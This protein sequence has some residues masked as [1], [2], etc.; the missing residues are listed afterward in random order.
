MLL[1]LTSLCLTVTAMSATLFENAGTAGGRLF[2]C[3]EL[4]A[5]PAAAVYAETKAART[6]EKD[7]ETK[8][9]SMAQQQVSA[10]HAAQQKLL[11]AIDRLKGSGTAVLY[12]L[13]RV[14]NGV[15]VRT[16][17]Q[18]L[19]E[20]RNIQGVRRVLPVP[21]QEPM[22]A[23]SVP[24]LGAPEVWESY[25]LTGKNVKIGIIDTGIDYFH[26][27]FG[28]S[29]SVEDYEANDPD[30]LGDYEFPTEKVVGGWDFAGGP[31]R[32][33][34]PDL[35]VPQPDPDPVDYAGHGSHVA[36][37]AAGFG[38]TADGET[39]SGPWTDTRNLPDMKIAPGVAPEALLYALKVFG[40]IE[41]ATALSLAAL[42]WALDPDGDGNFSD[43]LDVVNLSLGSSYGTIYNALTAGTQ[44]AAQA[45]LIIVASAGNSSDVYFI[46]GT[47]GGAENVLSVAASMDDGQIYTAIDVLAPA[48]AAGS[49]YVTR[50]TA[51]P[52][53]EDAQVTGEL[54]DAEPLMACEALGNPDVL[55]GRIALVDRGSCS[56]YDKVLNAQNAGAT[57]VIVV[58]NDPYEPIQVLIDDDEN[59]IQIPSVMIGRAAGQALRAAMAGEPV[60][61]SMTGGEDIVRTELADVIAPFSSRGPKHIQKR[62]ILKPDIAAP[63]M[64]ITSVKSGSGTEGV[65]WRGT[66]MACPHITGMMALLREA[67][68]GWSVNALKALA[69]NTA[70]HDLFRDE[71][72]VPPRISP[73][74]A[75]AGNADITAAL[76]GGVIAYHAARPG[77]V[78]LVFEN[79]DVTGQMTET[80]T[81]RLKNYGAASAQYS[82]NIDPAADV[83]GISFT[84]ADNTITVP[85]AGTA[86]LEITLTAAASGMSLSRAPAVYAAQLDGRPRYSMSEAAGYV[87]FTPA[88]DG[89]KLRVPYYSLARPAASMQAGS[90]ILN[91]VED[92][93]SI[94][95]PLTGTGVET[96][97][98]YPDDIVSL[99][100]PFELK[101]ESGCES[102]GSNGIAEDTDIRYAGVS[103]VGD[104]LYFG[105]VS[106]GLWGTPEEM[107][108]SVYIDTDLDG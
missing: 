67:H 30:V 64:Q 107:Y 42:E 104:T 84:A 46:T 101:Y 102:C 17:D 59:A 93:G 19:K 21:L 9:L 78:S 29:G 54:A 85:A 53:L 69:M 81:I 48:S 92:A 26:A 55:G 58:N 35:D 20:L 41:S 95:I 13:Q 90:D 51:G 76:A 79:I 11:A 62:P 10:N 80:R 23:S 34:D 71:V 57:G 108:F 27:D 60:T 77:A 15:V 87:T 49:H 103:T 98:G 25:G 6:A 63:G 89:P 1:F 39:F 44:Y 65:T 2:V 83:P 52:P 105:I 45:G 56:C 31:Y 3:L 66:S 40:D 61:V 14:L 16:T 7:S 37:S 33:S 47:P 70:T 86:D 75:G 100:T 74:R 5:P 36:G 82:V 88:D 68:P 12:T 18:E 22:H 4:E 106:H 96:G 50:A 43:R 73:A 24:F 91:L 99:V 38:V 28:G 8:A 97:V 72:N 32:P 94:N